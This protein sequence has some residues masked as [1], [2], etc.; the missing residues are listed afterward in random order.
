[1]ITDLYSLLQ[2]LIGDDN[3]ISEEDAQA[4]QNVITAAQ[5]AGTL[6]IT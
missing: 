1:V 2:T 5:V 4:A 6:D 3:Q